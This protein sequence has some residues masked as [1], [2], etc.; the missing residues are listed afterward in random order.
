[1]SGSYLAGRGIGSN[2]SRTQDKQEENQ[3]KNQGSLVA[4]A[5]DGNAQKENSNQKNKHQPVA[6]SVVVQEDSWVSITID[7]KMAF[8][9]TLTQGTEKT[10]EAQKQLVF[11]AGN[12]GGILIAFNNGQTMQLG[13]PGA[14][15]EV[16]F[17]ATNTQISQSKNAKN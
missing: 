10:W 11:L 9:G 13:K 15:E 17:T 5:S 2:N 12:A 1:M 4:Q 16:V 7:G 8:E 3:L 14:V 6:V